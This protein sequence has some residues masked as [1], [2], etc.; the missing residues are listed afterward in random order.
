MR[1]QKLDKN[2]YG[3]R[4][5]THKHKGLYY[6]DKKNRAATSTKVKWY[7]TEKTTRQY[8]RLLAADQSNKK[9]A[10]IGSQVFLMIKI[11]QTQICL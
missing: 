9:K 5:D 10:K 11:F 2:A 3:Q 4:V 6:I 1:F 7:F 8:E